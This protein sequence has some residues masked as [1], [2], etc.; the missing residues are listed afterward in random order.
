M[1]GSGRLGS[2]GERSF[3]GGEFFDDLRAAEVLREIIDLDDLLA[4]GF[5]AMPLL[6]LFAREDAEVA[7]RNGYV[8]ARTN[9]EFPGAHRIPQLLVDRL[10]GDIGHERGLEHASRVAWVF[11]NENAR[12]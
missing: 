6:D 1:N 10:A 7:G 4:Q 2:A 5:L 9:L 3:F 11:R 8:E 12:G